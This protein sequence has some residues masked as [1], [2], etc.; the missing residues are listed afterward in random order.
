MLL[1]RPPEYRLAGSLAATFWLL[2]KGASIVRT[3]DVAATADVV[4]VH[5]RLVRG[6]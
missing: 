4:K 6:A 2:Q 1:D 3:H 5:E